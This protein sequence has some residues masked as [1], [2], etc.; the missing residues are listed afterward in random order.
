M[1]R[2]YTI[3]DVEKNLYVYKNENKHPSGCADK[4]LV[5]LFMISTLST[6]VSLKLIR[7]DKCSGT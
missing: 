3:N 6:R 2:I 7:R 1:L 4:V 5:Y